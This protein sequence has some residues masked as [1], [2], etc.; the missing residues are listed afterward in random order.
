MRLRSGTQCLLHKRVLL[1]RFIHP[2]KYLHQSPGNW[3]QSFSIATIEANELMAPVR[4][5]VPVILKPAN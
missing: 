5:R 1:Q 4:D 2:L 3:V